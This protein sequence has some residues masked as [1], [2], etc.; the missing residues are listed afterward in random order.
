[1][2]YVSLFFIY[3]KGFTV[4]LSLNILKC[5]CGPVVLP[6]SKPLLKYFGPTY[7]IMSPLFTYVPTLTIKFSETR[8]YK[9]LIESLC[10]MISVFPYPPDKNDAYST[11]PQRLA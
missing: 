6:F 8:Q 3:S 5:K 9:V 1:M 11:I 4:E 7:P 10:D 2:L